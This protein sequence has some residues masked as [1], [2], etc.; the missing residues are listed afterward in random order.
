MKYTILALDLDG[1]LTNS[2]KEVTTETLNAVKRAAH[3]GVDVVLASGRPVL[4]IKNIAKELGLYESGGYI[5]A[6][7]GAEII[8]CKT[9]EFVSKKELPMKY[10]GIICETARKYNVNALTYDDVGILA[11]SDDAKYVIKEAV[12]NSISIKKVDKLEDVVNYPV[13]K[14]MIV[15]E[16]EQ[17]SLVKDELDKIL[18]ESI[19]VFFSE[20]YFLELTPKNIQKDTSLDLLVKHLGKIT[21]ELMCV[22]DGLNDIPMFKVSGL[23]VAMENAY[24]ETKKYANDITL[25]NDNDGVAYAIKKHIFEEI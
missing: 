7:N 15:G 3:A 13:P 25:S 22:G 6:Y 10:Y 12:N 17:L 23:A 11:E 1:T 21:D 18:G 19:S 5:L 9:G 16:P 24:P 8:N 14:F 20:P 4:G 2:K